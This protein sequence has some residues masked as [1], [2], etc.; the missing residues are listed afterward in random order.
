MD[1]EVGR[2]LCEM[3]LGMSLDK[4]RNLIELRAGAQLYS[5]EGMGSK[6]TFPIATVF[7]EWKELGECVAI[8][9]QA[10]Y[11]VPSS[12]SVKRPSWG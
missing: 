2:G 1:I 7:P 6:Q 10:I 8:R 4:S 11:L 12:R 3:I 9:E 5:L